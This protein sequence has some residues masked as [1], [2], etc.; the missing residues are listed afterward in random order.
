MT[1][2]LLASACGSRTSPDAIDRFATPENSGEAGADAYCPTAPVKATGLVAEDCAAYCAVYACLSCP[3]AVD[4]CVRSCVDRYSRP[5]DDFA[6]LECAV[7]H[8]TDDARIVTGLRCDDFNPTVDGIIP[9]KI[10]YPISA[11]PICPR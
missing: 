1:C 6:C 8:V 9:M 3:S 10:V 11:C 5:R 4:A 7:E 2:A